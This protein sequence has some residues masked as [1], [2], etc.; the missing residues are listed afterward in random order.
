LVLM[1]F[2]SPHRFS[3][4]KKIK[5]STAFLNRMGVI[6]SFCWDS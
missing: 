1:F 5:K 2:L 6:G 3:L 4:L